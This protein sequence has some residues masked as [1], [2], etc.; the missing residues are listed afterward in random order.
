ME[1]RRRH[2]RVTIKAISD[3]FCKDDNRRLKAFVGGISR[4]GL[5]IYSKT[6]LKKD[7]RLD[8]SLYF[9]D[10]E[11][12]SVQEEIN[13]QVRW[14]ALLEGDYISGIEFEREVA[15]HRTPALDEYLLTA[16][17]YLKID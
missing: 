15:P 4:G 9:K 6:E 10:K 13:G 7:C 11:G 12:N 17:D 16:E 2:Q 1:N 14:S 8:I 3:I 5:E